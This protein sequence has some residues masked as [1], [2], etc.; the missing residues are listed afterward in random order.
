MKTKEFNKMSRLVPDYNLD[1]QYPLPD[2]LD[3]IP[4]SDIEYYAPVIMYFA[5]D[6]YKH[7]PLTDKDD[8]KN[9]VAKCRE[10]LQK[11]PIED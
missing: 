1:G 7:M 9:T 10:L 6:P 2:E 3:A 8:Y 4:E 11:I 5:A